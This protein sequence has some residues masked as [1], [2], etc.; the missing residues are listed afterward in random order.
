V[1]HEGTLEGV[2]LGWFFWGEQQKDNE[3]LAK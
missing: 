2:L 1:N 3:R